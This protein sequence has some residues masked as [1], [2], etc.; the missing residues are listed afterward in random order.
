MIIKYNS[1][2]I[3]LTAAMTLVEAVVVAEIGSI[4]RCRATIA[5]NCSG[6]R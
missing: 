1:K 6:T 2:G 5:F 3:W 4:E